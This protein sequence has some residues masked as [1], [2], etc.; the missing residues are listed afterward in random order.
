M[1]TTATRLTLGGL[2]AL[3][4]CLPTESQAGAGIRFGRFG[5]GVGS[6]GFSA[7]RVGGWYAPYYDSYPV[8]SA[9]RVYD[10]DGYRTY[11]SPGYDAVDG[12]APPPP[13]DSA[14]TIEIVNPEGNAPLAYDVN[15]FHFE[16][17]PGQTQRL[18]DDRPW[19]IQFDKGGD[20][21]DGAYSLE[22]G[23][24]KFVPTAN[25]WD[26]VKATDQTGIARRA[27]PP[28]LPSAE[29]EVTTVTPHTLDEPATESAKTE[30]ESP[31]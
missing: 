19:V 24:Y 13:M 30:T 15:Q 28:P 3:G 14:G 23:R 27:A 2:M 1:I 20:F 5:I 4:L 12:P 18:D 29:A 9:Y 16:I 26:L 25:G 6:G 8:Y 21:G 31:R 17:E 10:G 22:A 11:Y 7:G